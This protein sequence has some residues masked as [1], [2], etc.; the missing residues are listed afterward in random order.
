MLISLVIHNVG[1]QKKQK[2]FMVHFCFHLVHLHNDNVG[3]PSDVSKAFGYYTQCILRE[4]F[5]NLIC[6]TWY[7]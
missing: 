1:K 3:G 2:Y 5:G 7:Q 6:F 4:H